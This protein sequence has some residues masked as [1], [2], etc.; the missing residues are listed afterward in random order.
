MRNGLPVVARRWCVCGPCFALLFSWACVVSSASAG[1]YHDF[2]C[3]IPYGPGV[4]RPAPAADV[5]YSINGDFLYAGN[6]CAEGGSLY[7]AMDGGTTHPYE[8]AALDT[9]LAPAGLTISG[10]TVWRYEADFPGQPYG[11][12][13]SNLA[14]GPGP[15]SVQGLCTEGCARGI[16]AVPLSPS[17]VVSVPGLSG[18]TQIQWS[19][20]CGGGPGGSCPSS[21]SGTL[22]SQY[23]VYAA[24]VDLV[25]DTPPTVSGVSGPLVGGG[26]L[27][28]RQ[29]VSFDTSDSQS[30]VYGGSLLVDGHTE[31][32]QVLDT[33]GG[34]CQSLGSTPDGQRSFEYAQPCPATVSGAL[35]L[36]TSRLAP[37]SHSLELI[38]EDAA[39]N[40]TV[41]YNGTITIGGPQSV[42][43]GIGPGSAAALRGAPNGTN[44]S[45]Q[46][47]L[48]ARWNGTASATRTSRYGQ[49]D[50][51]TGRLMTPV[52]QPISGALLDISETP[53]YEGA[54]T[55][56]VPGART[57]PDGEW[58]LALPRSVPSSKLRFAYRSHANDTIT[59]ATVSLAL[60][61]HAGIAL[62]IAPRVTSVG[63]RIIFTGVVHGTP[64]PPGGKQLVLEA[65]SGGGWIEFDTIT[66]SANGDYRATYR[67]K[68]PG[69]A[70][71]RFRVLSPYEADFPFLNGVSNVVGVLE[72]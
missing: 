47:K 63:H 45:D 67:F 70:A 18:V 57:E 34:A 21:G 6:T 52:G 42:G 54:K 62:R 5:T 58:T 53:A 71:Y 66:T 56:P 24:D 20:S 32:S 16:Q 46:A 26:T 12:P 36:E 13:A 11:T 8:A 22:S 3:R 49:A 15:P 59:V 55:L 17:N 27:T 64:V 31:V 39:G 41:A 33:N 30:G 72:R 48:T 68:F 23:D 9:F 28:G 19:A 60:R 50:R 38:V 61:V 44:S 35:T 65:S 43:T 69:P 2:L 4:G 29:A 14:Y 37:G 40:Q 1:G 25:D 10:F 51:I 7:V